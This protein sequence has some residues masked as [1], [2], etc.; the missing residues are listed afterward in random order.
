MTNSSSLSKTLSLL[1]IAVALC[2]VLF[3]LNLGGFSGLILFQY[4]PSIGGLNRPV[5]WMVM[6]KSV[7]VSKKQIEAFSHAVHHANNR[8]IQATNARMVLK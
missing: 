1:S 2:G 7:S 8:P 4:H 6:K 3:L 5:L